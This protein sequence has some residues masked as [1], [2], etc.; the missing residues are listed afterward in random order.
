V[1]PG[2]VV[3]PSYD[4]NKKKDTYSDSMTPKRLT[5]VGKYLL[6]S[7]YDST[8]NH[9]SVIYCLDKKTGKY[10]KTIQVPGAPHLGGIAYD[11]VAKNIWVTGS[12]DDSSALMSFSLKKIRRAHV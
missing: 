8:H 2:Q 12:Q 10:L 7:A 3:T 6:I 11:P 4:F 1:I 5:V 9:R